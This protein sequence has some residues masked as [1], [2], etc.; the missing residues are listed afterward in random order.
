[1]QQSKKNQFG[2]RWVIVIYI[3]SVLE[4]IG[5]SIYF[6]ASLSDPEMASMQVQY[7]DAQQAP[8]SVAEN[9]ACHDCL[10]LARS[11]HAA[12]LKR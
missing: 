6:R 10:L 5:L 3:V 11:P 4:A 12:P 8:A 1:M 2:P 9:P 7:L